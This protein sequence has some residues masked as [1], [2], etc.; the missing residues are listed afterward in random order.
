MGFIPFFLISL[1]LRYEPA[2]PHQAILSMPAKNKYLI[3]DG[4]LLHGTLPPPSK[5][6]L[7]FW[8]SVR[9]TFLVNVWHQIPA[10]PNC[11]PLDYEMASRYG[12]H[13]WGQFI[14]RGH[15][16]HM[17]R[18]VDNPSLSVEELHRTTVRKSI[19]ESQRKLFDESNKPFKPYVNA[20]RK[21]LKSRSS[22]M[23]QSFVKSKDGRSSFYD[24]TISLPGGKSQP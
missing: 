21:P 10:A 14:P 22:N 16:F 7:S 4:I 3:F 8:P 6:V 19:E 17:L 12:V 18:L 15:P 24:Y 9:T 5:D 2:K 23:T 11:I 1:F 13:V 20:L